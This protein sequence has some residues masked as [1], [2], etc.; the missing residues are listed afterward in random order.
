MTIR[1]FTMKIR[2]VT[3]LAR[4][5]ATLR[6]ER[7]LTVRQQKALR[8]LAQ[9]LDSAIASKAVELAYLNPA[10]CDVGASDIGWLEIAADRNDDPFMTAAALNL[11]CN[12][13]GNGKAEVPRILKALDSVTEGGDYLCKVGCSMA[14][15][16][17][18]VHH[19]A[20]LIL[21]LYTVLHDPARGNTRDSARDAFLR[22][23]GMS[24]PD[25]IRA[26]SE[27][28]LDLWKIADDIAERMIA[29]GSAA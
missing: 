4:I 19:D 25:I 29:T 28:Q 18:L 24:T 21:A 17:L 2:D 11:L 13:L 14:G 20:V 7:H 6:K 3:S 22:L 10:L 23:S 12:W 15:K 5:S 27:S 26:E 1:D 8:R 16:V 9:S